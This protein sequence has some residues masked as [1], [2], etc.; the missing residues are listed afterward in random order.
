M[1]QATTVDRG[2]WAE[3]FDTL[4]ADH[5]GHSAANLRLRAAVAAGLSPRRF[6]EESAVRTSLTLRCTVRIIR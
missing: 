2:K 5:A 6:T 3:F 1:S 4:S